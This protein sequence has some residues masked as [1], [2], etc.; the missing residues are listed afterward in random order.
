MT[1]ELIG[2]DPLLAVEVKNIW[3]AGGDLQAADPHAGRRSF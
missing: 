3:T 1:S 2:S